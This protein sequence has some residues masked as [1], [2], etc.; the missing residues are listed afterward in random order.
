MKSKNPKERVYGRKVVDKAAT[1][2]EEIEFARENWNHADMQ[3]AVWA[4]EHGAEQH[5]EAMNAAGFQ[6]AAKE[7]W[8][9][10]RYQGELWMGNQITFGPNKI[11]GQNFARPK[12]FDNKF[13]AFAN[14][15]VLFN[16]QRKTPGGPPLHPY[17]T[18]EDRASQLL[19]HTVARGLHL[20]NDQHWMEW[21][22]SQKDPA[23]GKPIAIKP[24]LVQGNIEG[25]DPD[26]GE[27]V[28]KK[29]LVPKPPGP[30]YTLVRATENGPAMAIRDDYLS[31]VKMALA[32]SRITEMPILGT[33]H[34]IASMLKHDLLLML[35]SFHLM[36]LGQYSLALGAKDWGKSLG[37]KRGISALTW[38][39]GDL[40]EAVAKGLV[41][42]EAADWA[43]QK[44]P[45]FNPNGTVKRYET[46]HARIREALLRGMNAAANA[47]TLYRD[48]IQNTPFVGEMWS[49]MLSPANK[50]IFDKVTPGMIAESFIKN[51]ERLHKANPKIPYDALMRDVIRDTNVFYGNLG[52]QG[53][54]KHPTFRDLASIVILAPLWREG[55]LRKEAMFWSRASGLSYLRGR[56][57]MGA[58]AY[59]GTLGRGV[60]MGL[61]AW[62]AAAQVINLISK[63]HPTWQNE[64]EGHALDAWIPTPFGKEG[65]GV[66]IS[67]LGVFAELSHDLIRLLETKPKAWDAVTQVSANSMGP[68]GRLSRILATGKSPTGQEYSTTG[69][70]LWGATKELLPVPIS[71]GTPLK[72]LGVGAPL[73]PGEGL[74]RGIA[75][76]TGTKS[77]LA[78]RPTQ[79]I[80]RKAEKWLRSEGLKFEPMTFSPTDQASYAKLRGAVRNDDT[81]GARKVLEELR[82]HKTDAQILHA[83]K[84]FS[85]HPFTGTL[86][87]ERQFLYSLDNKDLDLYQRATQERFETFEKAADL[88]LSQ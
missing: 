77:S 3:A 42:K 85:R 88:V 13:R 87:N 39:E 7:N 81:K 16:R 40:P 47:D 56:R 60:A 12:T 38:S 55:L 52:R 5:R 63:G 84:V 70:V 32:P 31:A 68:I 79:D 35:D 21:L 80:Q 83:L 29:T 44:V 59:M 4:F 76:L 6:L 20:A 78:T 50:F 30:D 37:Y 57:G 15:S 27:I 74:Q 33:A 51:F 53:F 67:T 34:R 28:V 10:G 82:Q 11:L 17:I 23:T 69:G 48:A 36:R 66:W 71:L 9:P 1:Y 73:R 19:Q 41:S 46:R 25:E 65:S 64:E 8:F 72:A 75:T 43:L 24:K 86:K 26:T 62:F 61:G 54:F 14:P 2:K 18:V 58:D 49:K 22:R 45:V